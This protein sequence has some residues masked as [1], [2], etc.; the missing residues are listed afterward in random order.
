MLMAQSILFVCTG[1][2]FRSMVAEY[3]VRAD[4]LPD[5]EQ[6]LSKA[7]DDV[8]SIIDHIGNAAPSLLARLPPVL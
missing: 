8:E 1:N 7:R 2:V 5:W 4:A 3:A 6:D